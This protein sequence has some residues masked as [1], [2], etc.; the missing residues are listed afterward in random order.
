MLAEG[1]RVEESE[2]WH[3]D[4]GNQLWAT[5]FKKPYASYG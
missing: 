3:F 4:Y 5:H 1:F 2:W